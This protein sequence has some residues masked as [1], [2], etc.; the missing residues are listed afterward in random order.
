RGLGKFRA[1]GIPGGRDR[2]APHSTMNLGGPSFV[3][4][5]QA[6][7]PFGIIPPRPR[8]FE[9]ASGCFGAR[10]RGGLPNLHLSGSQASPGPREYAVSSFL[11]G[12]PRPPISLE[13]RFSCPQPAPCGASLPN[14]SG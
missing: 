12:C 7:R 4:Q 1:F 11:A 13:E 9:S 14:G 10:R 8:P 6:T 3:G 2:R 5:G